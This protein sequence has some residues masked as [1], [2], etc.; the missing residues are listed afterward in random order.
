MTFFVQRLRCRSLASLSVWL[1]FATGA[2]MV[3]LVAQELPPAIQADRFLLQA[4]QQI[5]AED[6]D[7]ALATLNR[8]LELQAEYDLEVPAAFWFNHARVAMQ[9]GDLEEAR[10]S[11][12]QYLQLA[13]QGAEHYIAALEVLNEVDELLAAAAAA[14]AAEREAAAAAAAEREAERLRVLRVPEELLRQAE[15]SAPGR[16]FR[17]CAGCP[18]MVNVPPGRFMMGSPGSEEGRY[19]DEGPRHEVTIGY[20]LAVGV[21]EVTFVEWDAC[22]S[23]GGC[24]GYRPIDRGLG[25]GRRPAIT[26]SWEDAQAY[27][28]WLSRETGEEYRLLSESEWEY[29]AR[30]GTQTARYWGGSATGQCRYANGD[31]DSVSCSDGYAQTAPVGW[32]QPNAFGLYDVLGNVWEWV[33]DCWNGNYAG[34]PADGNPWTSGD[35]SQR[36]LRGGSWF[37]HPD[38]LRSAFRSRIS[39]GLRNYYD[40]FRLARTIN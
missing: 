12:V 20:P 27:V 34:A 29:V 1:V 11:A 40:G 10:A 8:I 13:G 22:V 5:Q 26:V 15:A 14:A 6:Y 31:D 16:V 19:D 38:D 30:A 33:E 24:G 3:Q 35:C 2:G 36:V 4:E 25:R 17:D 28:A 37:N 7:A 21:Y 9:A 23:A 18:V 39:A 32:F